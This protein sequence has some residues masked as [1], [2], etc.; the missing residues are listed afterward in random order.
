MDACREVAHLV[1]TTKCQYK[2]WGVASHT[3]LILNEYEIFTHQWLVYFKLNMFIKSK[4]MY[5]LICILHIIN[6]WKVMHTT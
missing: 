5:F 2:S 1:K 3:P 4:K 6:H